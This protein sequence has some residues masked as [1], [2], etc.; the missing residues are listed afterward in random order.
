MAKPIPGI[1]YWPNQSEWPSQEKYSPKDSHQDKPNPVSSLIKQAL[2]FILL[3]ILMQASWQMVR[4]E[5]VGYFI[6][7]TVI[8]KPAVMLIHLLTPKI[9]ASALGNQI[10]APGGGLVI[11]IGC[12][13]VEALFIL[14]AGLLSVAIGWRAKLSGI[15]LGLVLIYTVNELRI[16]LLFYA[17]RADKA[18]F[19]L[20]HGTIAPLALITI[21]GLFYHY[22]LQKNQPHLNAK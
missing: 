20:L 14:I 10:L 17:F 8:V 19:Q 2:V 3:F 16:L 6:R 11:K 15:I 1:D 4:D 13:G 7:G 12:E 21:A 5:T 22:W 9:E 18:L